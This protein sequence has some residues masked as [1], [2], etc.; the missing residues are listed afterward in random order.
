[1]VASYEVLQKNDLQFIIYFFSQLLPAFKLKPDT[2]V[3]FLAFDQII[4]ALHGDIPHHMQ[5]L[6]QDLKVRGGLT[7]YQS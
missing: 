7:N 1:M 4:K 6:L 5:L 2:V 3:N